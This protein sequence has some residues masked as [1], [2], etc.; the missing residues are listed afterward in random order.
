MRR[1]WHNVVAFWRKYEHHL[2]VGAM[3]VGFTFDIILAKR[4]DSLVDNVLLLAYLFAAGC[5]IIVLNLR[6]MRYNKGAEPLVLLLIL[7]FCFGGLASN[8]LVLYGHSGTLVGSALFLGMLVALVIGNE[9]LRT[10][11]VRLRF[12][13]GVY[14]FL[15]LT[16]V[17]IAAPTF[18]FHGVSTL[19]FVGSGFLSLAVFAVFA[20]AL[21]AAV[22][23]GAERR[24][25]RDITIIVATTFALF[26]GLYFLDVIPPVPLSLK[27]IGVYH[28]VLHQSQGG[29]IALFEAAPWW[30]LWR[31]TSGT[32]TIAGE[33][34][35]FCFSS[36]FAPADLSTTIYHRWE[37]YD[38]SSGQWVTQSRISYAINGGLSEGYHGYTIKSVSPGQW[39]CDVETSSGALI[40]RVGFSVVKSPSPPALSQSVL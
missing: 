26:N 18:I 31:D 5:L 19:V 16:Y 6:E 28:S 20:A 13:V 33:N 9:F 1:A 36:V 2:G 39:R 12:N 27:S 30:E 8:L 32:F 21:W 3:V 40:G 34:T 17:L 14:Y 37:K 23:R 11:Y 22:L 10:R 25:A 15:L 4:P 7:Q 29:Y 24:G 35:A 38:E